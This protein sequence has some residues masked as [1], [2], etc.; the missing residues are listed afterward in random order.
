M[1]KYLIHSNELHLISKKRI[2]Q[3]VEQIVEDLDIAAGS[4]A[5]FNLYAVVENYFTNLEKRKDINKLLN[6]E[7][8][9]CEVIEE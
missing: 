8:S 3:A 6:I 9:P 1:E 4:T 2:H 5:G 7:I